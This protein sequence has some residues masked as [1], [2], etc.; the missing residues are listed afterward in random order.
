MTS[1]T[2]R[3]L[4]ALREEGW[5]AEVVEHWNMH[6]KQ[7]KDLFGFADIIA[8]QNGV[9]LLVQA[10]SQSNVNARIKKVIANEIALEWLKQGLPIWVVGWK[11]YAEPVARKYWRSS[12]TVMTAE[13]V[14][15]TNKEHCDGERTLPAVSS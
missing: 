10:T 11:K 4:A 6:T 14:N 13:I 12:I 15:D 1:P 7:R 3:T 9:V 5:R 2:S 8:F